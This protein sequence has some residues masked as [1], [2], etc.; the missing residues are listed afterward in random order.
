MIL[1]QIKFP[2]PSKQRQAKLCGFIFTVTVY[3]PHLKIN[4]FLAFT[5]R[6]HILVLY[7]P[8]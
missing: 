4:F 1:W 8:D 7:S 5:C 2:P 3:S 6:S